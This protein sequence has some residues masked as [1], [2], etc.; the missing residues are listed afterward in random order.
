MLASLGTMPELGR[1]LSGLGGCT[2]PVRLDGHRTEYAVNKATGEIGDVLHHLDSAT[3]PA[4]QLLVRCNNRRATRC[5]ACAETYRRDTYHLITAG[6]RG[7][8]GASEAVA[9]HPRVFATLTAP[10]FGPVHNRPNGGRDCR[11]GIRH[12]ENDPAL[13]TALD[14]DTYDYEAAVL[15]NA[16]AGALWRRF[17]IYLRREVAK[18][19]GLTQRA[20]LDHARISFAKVAE[21]QRRGAV[22]FHAVIRLDGPEGGET[23]P[24]AWASTE[25]LTDAIPA[26]ATAT[27]IAGPEV[28]GRS[29]RFVFGRQLDVR[30]IRS[31]DF[32]GGQELTERAVAAYIAKYATKGAETA[33]GTLDRPIRFLAELAQARISDHAQRM[34]RTAWSLGARA[35]LA[36]LRL[37]AWAHMLGFRGHF[38][39]KSRRYS[40][41]LGALRD[42]RAEWRRAQ[43]AET[44]TAPVTSE[45]SEVTSTLVLAHWVF[46]G[47][48]LSA[49]ET[50]LAASLEPAPGTEGEPT[51]G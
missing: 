37:R 30:P 24:P 2:H 48:G 6:L 12:D 20:F 34:I 40:T 18:R 11:C 19:A 50:W 33:T 46:A 42:A 45:I 39:T 29:H 17:S 13:G 28:D 3:L 47:T 9:T 7:G 8:K 23:A 10:S 1:Q 16:H 31:A 15:W 14:P 32:D 4:G 36:D 38:S 44:S 51:H 26:A 5:A 41:T 25:V 43:A 22:H 35:D 21:Y 49:A 27:R